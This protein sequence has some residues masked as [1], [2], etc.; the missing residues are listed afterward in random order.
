MLPGRA[1]VHAYAEQREREA[2][3]LAAVAASLLGGGPVTDELDGIATRAAGV[4][5]VPTRWI[6]LG[7]E[8]TDAPG[9]RRACPSRSTGGG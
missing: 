8:A 6:A 7:D 3:L 2:A 9:R 4:L 5:G 1:G